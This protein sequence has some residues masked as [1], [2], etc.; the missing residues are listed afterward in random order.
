[1][2]PEQIE[3]ERAA[4]EA[5]H[6]P[7]EVLERNPIGEYS[8]LFAAGLFKVWLG[9]AEQGGWISVEEDLPDYGITVLTATEEGFV[10]TGCLVEERGAEFDCIWRFAVTS[11]PITHW[12][13]LPQPPEGATA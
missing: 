9:R 13:P 6:S 8:D 1:M 7:E 3:Q 5:W 11:S 2:T 10:S 4:F 12:Q